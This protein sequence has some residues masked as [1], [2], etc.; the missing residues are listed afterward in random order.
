[1][2]QSSTQLL[3]HLTTFLHETGTFKS[4]DR[5]SWAC[6]DD[7]LPQLC[8]TAS[9]IGNGVNTTRKRKTTRSFTTIDFS[10]ER[11]QNEISL[12]P[13]LLPRHP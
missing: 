5:P 3:L 8:G 7:K 1:M 10:R 13:V 9:R 2:L 6:G 11:P 12:V 4:N